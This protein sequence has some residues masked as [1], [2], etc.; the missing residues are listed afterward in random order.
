MPSYSLLSL[1]SLDALT[2]AIAMLVSFLTIIIGLYARRYLAG[3][4]HYRQFYGL[5]VTLAASAILMAASDHLLVF[6]LSWSISNTAL[7]LLITHKPQWQAAANSGWLTAKTF[8]IGI[9]CLSSALLLLY[10]DTGQTSIK[11]I[12]AHIEPNQILAMTA[13]ACLII[14]AMTQSAI[15]PFH[16][17]LISSANAPT[18]VSAIMHAG[19]VNGGGILLA[20]F[21]P[22]FFSQPPL[23]L[24]IFI[25]GI[26]TAI[27][28]SLWKLMQSDIKRMLA[29][30]TM[31][32]MGFMFA[33]IG[34]GLFPA[35][36]A[37]LCW[38][39]LFKANLF[40]QA[41]GV[42]QD[43]FLESHHQITSMEFILG[44]MIGMIGG[45][46]FAVA[47]QQPMLVNDT[48]LFLILIVIITASQFS[49]KLLEKPTL[50]IILLSLFF[51]T[52]AC[53]TY[54]YSILLIESLLKPMN[55]MQPQSLNL[56]HA[57][58]IILLVTAWLLMNFKSRVSCNEKIKNTGWMLYVKALNASQPH[59]KTITTYRHQYKYH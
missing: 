43:K 29:C 40:L 16:R 15:W 27:T 34:L 41:Y 7:V 50:K 24:F 11:L 3:D 4:S 58:A 46:I 20:K 5:L 39:G 10:L 54:G 51:T 9:T 31:A 19:L 8:L 33:Q 17:W 38:H 35:A 42:K 52:L 2:V 25:I 44:L 26:S 28:G 14:T 45:Y 37:H 1:F 49:I 55:L 22:L 48:R 47:N 23:L 13:A 53:A 6:L 57:A 18:P 21:A 36:I 59:P 12:T 32:Q 30:S 56:F